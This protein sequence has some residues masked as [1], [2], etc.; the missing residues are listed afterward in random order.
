MPLKVPQNV[1]DSIARVSAAGKY[2]RLVVVGSVAVGITSGSQ[3]DE[4]IVLDALCVPREYISFTQPLDPVPSEKASL[5]SQIADGSLHLVSVESAVNELFDSVPLLVDVSVDVLCTRD[6]AVCTHHV[7]VADGVLV[8]GQ[9]VKNS[10]SS[11]N[12]DDSLSVEL[13]DAL[14]SV[15]TSRSAPP[16][17][18]FIGSESAEVCSSS[19]KQCSPDCGALQASRLLLCKSAAD[20]VAFSIRWLDDLLHR[21]LVGNV[22]KQSAHYQPEECLLP[23]FVQNA[24]EN[25]MRRA[26]HTALMLPN[27]PRLVP[28]L[29]SSQDT[30]QLFV[31]AAACRSQQLAANSNAGSVHISRYN[32]PWEK[33][34][35]RNPHSVVQKTTVIEGSTTAIVKGDY[36]YYHYRV[37]GFVDDGWGCAYRSLQT[38]LSWFQYQG[39][40]AEQRVPSVTDIQKILKR[41]DF[42]KDAM[43]HFVGSREWIGSYEVMMVITDFLPQ[44]ECQLKRLDCGEQLETDTELHR[45]LLQHFECGGAPIMIGGSSYAHT[46]LGIDVNIRIGEVQYLIL[47]PHYSSTVTDMKTV[48]NKGWCG[49]KKPSKFFEG[50]SFYNL[51]IPCLLDKV[52]FS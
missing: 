46:I 52:D 51:C 21:R 19:G 2:C 20:A 17:K 39:V 11:P 25:S 37:D 43:P 49:W 22:A 14:K 40:L 47:D 38:V 26:V 7:V 4:A 18:V 42:G 3:S 12:F 44:M 41:V 45:L 16:V 35:Q 36:D 5:Q 6:A 24:T 50:K 10:R 28:R 9:P 48:K 33:H 34:L 13:L 1:A 8:S 29:T 23:V 15:S 32:A 30:S 31:S 27:R